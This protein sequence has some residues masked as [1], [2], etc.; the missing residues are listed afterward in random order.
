MEDSRGIGLWP[1]LGIET[2]AS[3]LRPHSR[4]ID[5]VD[6]RRDAGRTEHFLR[7]DTDLVCFS[8]NWE[9]ERDF[10]REEIASVP[11]AILTVVG[12]R[13]ATEDPQKWLSDCP[14]V[15]ILVRGDGEET[16]GEIAS[17]GPLAGIAGISYRADGRV[18]HNP[19]RHCAPVRDD[20]YPD[21]KLRR[22]RYTFDVGGVTGL[23]FDTVA[24][25]RGCPFN[26]RFCSFNRNPW[27]EKRTWTARS[28]RLTPTSSASWTTSSRTTPTASRPYARFSGRAASGSGT[29]SRPGSR[30]R[31]GPTFSGR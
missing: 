12:G 9:R 10:V 11:A 8:V 31:A 15:D 19:V 24:S 17:G 18:V 21:R 7:P 23:P 1:P 4:R 14:N 28:R 3:A 20:L 5:V 25:S 22:Y 16:I 6:L 13:H 29:W 27:G 30:S 2:I 26:C